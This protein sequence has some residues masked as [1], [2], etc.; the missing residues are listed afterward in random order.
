M[1]ENITSAIQAAR[2]HLRQER[3][4][5]A[6]AAIEEEL[7]R[8]P[9]QLNLLI[10][11][12]KIYRHSGNYNKALHCSNLL[13]TYH[14]FNWHGYALKAASLADLRRLDEAACAIQNG[15]N[16]FPSQ[17]NLLNASIKIY[18]ELYHERSLESALLQIAIDPKQLRGY[19]LAAASLVALQRFNKAYELARQGLEKLPNQLEL[20]VIAAKALAKTRNYLQSLKYADRAIEHHPDHWEGYTIAALSLASLRRSQEAINRLSLGLI[21]LPIS[22]EITEVAADVSLNSGDIDQFFRY[23]EALLSISPDRRLKYTQKRRYVYAACDYIK[24]RGSEACASQATNLEHLYVSDEFILNADYIPFNF[25]YCPKNACTSVKNSLLRYDLPSTRVHKDAQITLRHNIDF[26]KDF[27]ILTRN[28]YRRFLSAYANKISH[29]GKKSIWHSMCSRYGFRMDSQP[30]MDSI[31]DCLLEDD[32]REIDRHFKPQAN[33]FCS[34]LIKPSYI[35]RIERMEEFSDFLF[36]QGFKLKTCAP[37]S[38]A[39]SAIEIC[40]LDSRI[41]S[42]IHRLY[43]ADFELYGYP[44]DPSS[45]TSLVPNTVIQ[46]QVIDPFLRNLKFCD[47]IGG[48]GHEDISN[49]LLN[50]IKE[51]DEAC[52]N[53]GVASIAGSLVLDRFSPISFLTNL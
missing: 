23:F 53:R 31:L 21:R 25:I 20:L 46:A 22:P 35:F 13:I 15:L 12:V 33:I 6:E 36:Q 1:S 18:S 26:E 34:R 47:N 44:D 27:V 8:S 19:E 9:R 43:Q 10:E 51:E 50:L 45:T 49:R 41:I 3:I 52:I 37:H 17:E 40:T 42:K 14:P 38:T 11:A 29:A 24:Q 2:I 32:I 39:K 4:A 48:D 7:T 28:P 5:E 16:K 30:C